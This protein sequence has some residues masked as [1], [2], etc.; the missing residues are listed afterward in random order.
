MDARDTER[1]ATASRAESKSSR[2]EPGVAMEREGESE[3]PDRPVVRLEVDGDGVAT[4]RLDRP[5][6]N[7][8]DREVADAIAAAADDAARRDDVGAVVVWGGRTL[9]AA[10]ADIKAMAGLGSGDITPWVEALGRACDAL[11]AVPKVTIAAINGFA[12]GGG[13]ELALACDLRFAAEDAE[14]GQPEVLIGVMPGAGATQR[15]PRLVGEGRAKDLILF[16]RR[17]SAGEAAAMGLVTRVLPAADVY[18]AAVRAA[19]AFAAGP[20]RAFSAAKAAIH[21]ARG[22]DLRA[23]LE[24]ERTSFCELFSTADRREG[25]AAFL[26]KRPPRFQ[27]R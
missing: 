10:G 4:L 14:L 20:R 1:R 21:L 17:I 16:G 3:A 5:P 27:G 19:V 8:L 18:P 12:L 24:A 22:G 9:F 26:A 7:A 11:E 15:L 23:A 13:C 2:N 6:A 25:M